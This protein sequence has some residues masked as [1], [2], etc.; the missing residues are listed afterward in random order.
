MRIFSVFLPLPILSRTTGALILNVFYYV[1]N[2]SLFVAEL[3]F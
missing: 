2:T 1:F 3:K